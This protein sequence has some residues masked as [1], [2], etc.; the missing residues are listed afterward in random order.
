MTIK[1]LRKDFHEWI[2]RKEFKVNPIFESARKEYFNIRFKEAPD[3]K[4]IF[5]EDKALFTVDLPELNIHDYMVHCL[6]ID[7]HSDNQGFYC[8]TCENKTYFNNEHTLYEDHFYIPTQEWIN[9]F[10]STDRRICFYQF[11]D[12]EAFDLKFLRMEDLD[13]DKMI[14]YRMLVKQIIKI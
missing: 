11:N 4:I 6:E 3:I 9:E 14:N 10:L 8:K 13:N 1:E 12:G 2:K 5:Y 7:K